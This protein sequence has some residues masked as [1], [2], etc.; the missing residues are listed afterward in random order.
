MGI[1]ENHV[2]SIEALR[3]GLIEVVE[4]GNASKKWFGRPDDTPQKLPTQTSDCVNSARPDF[5]LDSRQVPVDPSST[6]PAHC[7]V[8]NYDNT[9]VTTHV[10][11]IHSML[12]PTR[13][14][15]SMEKYQHD[16]KMNIKFFPSL[17]R[18]V[19][20]SCSKAGLCG[21]TLPS[22]TSIS[23]AQHVVPPL[24]PTVSAS[25]TPNT[26]DANAVDNPCVRPHVHDA[27]LPGAVQ[28][29]QTV[30]L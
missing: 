9:T 5:E 14:T 7:H 2:P 6:S 19:G 13:M 24:M 16:G 23:S 26:I 12:N 18:L 1:L 17:R 29:L 28:T 21:V 4:S 27:N 22:F 11:R 10:P 30:S 25:C 8:H 20:L 15:L 3:P